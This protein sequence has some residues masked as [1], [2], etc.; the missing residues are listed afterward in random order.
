MDQAALDLVKQAGSDW[1]RRNSLKW[2]DVEPSEGEINWNAVSTLEMEIASASELGLEMVLIV[3]STPQWAQLNP[4]DFCGPVSYE[5]LPAFA[6]FLYEAVKRYSAPPYNVKYWEFGNEPDIDPE[7]VPSESPFGCW[8]DKTDIFY[9]GSYFAEMLKQVYP[10]VK[11][12][13]PESQVLVGGLLLDCDPV[14]PPEGKD[15][16]PSL[17]LEGILR[18]GGGDF[19]DGISFHAYDYYSGPFQYGNANWNSSWDSTGPV[20]IAKTRY[21]RSL[22][23]AYQHPEKFLMNTEAGLI[24]A[25][26]DGSPE[27]QTP[28]FEQ[29]KANYIAQ[30]NLAALAEKLRANI[31]YSLTGWRGT[32][33][34]DDRGDPFPAYKAFQFNSSQMLGAAYVRTITDVP[35][36]WGY[37]LQKADQ[38]IQI[39]WSIDGQ[40]HDYPFDRR[41][42]AVYNVF[43]ELSEPGDTTVN[44][45]SGPMYLVWN[46]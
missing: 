28:E 31:W 45:R 37:E 43:G 20:L 19:F 3:N 26:P 32:A 11:A 10:R 39:L 22:L 34:V 14:N 36:L 33:L 13:D 25:F 17:F 7:F 6:N 18:S 42:E 16:T 2:S 29:T 9:G 41:P 21:L 1:I 40:E 27:C 8:G 12:A 44:I 5:K 35:G 15:C 38:R 46:L 24:C 4:G 23:A 30:V